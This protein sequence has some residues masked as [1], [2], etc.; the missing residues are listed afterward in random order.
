MYS[1]SPIRL[2]YHSTQHFHSP[3][4]SILAAISYRSTTVTCCTI[5]DNDFG[6]WNQNRV[7]IRV[8]D[9]ASGAKQYCKKNT[10]SASPI[11]DSFCHL[12]D[13]HS[14]VGISSAACFYTSHSQCENITL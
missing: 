5:N 3:E 12:K 2:L 6:T 13:S 7:S 14:F 9:A 10:D 1:Y 11:E 8:E 4:L